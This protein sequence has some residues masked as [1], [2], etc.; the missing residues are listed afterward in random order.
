MRDLTVTGCL[1]IGDKG[2]MCLATGCP[3]LTHL[4]VEGLQ[5]LTDHSIVALA[6]RC[7][8]LISL[9][10]P[11]CP[12]NLTEESLVAISSRCIHLQ[13]FKGIGGK[14]TNKSLLT[15]AKNCRQ[16]SHIDISGCSSVNEES[17]IRF[18]ESSRKLT[19]INLLNT[20][21]SDTCFETLCDNCAT[22]KCL[23]VTQVT[24]ERAASLI[25]HAR[26]KFV[27]LMI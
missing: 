1:R 16:L 20:P 3:S 27:V 26:N 17:L 6:Q 23:F 13:E 14:F 15:L 4:N 9:A 5:K 25:E 19:A 22:L 12:N 10:L 21:I 24:G 8:N 18:F 7:T 11:G 2:V